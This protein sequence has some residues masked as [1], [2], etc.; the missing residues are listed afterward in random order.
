MIY[1]KVK[2]QFGTF[3][4]DG[5]LAAVFLRDTMRTRLHDAE[6]IVFDFEGVRN[7]N[8]SFCN[9]LIASLVHQLN[10]DLHRLAFRNCRP[11]LEILIRSAIE[12]G[13][14][15]SSAVSHRVVVR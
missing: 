9:S 2:E 8:S 1:V 11:G 12:M 13:L 10:G 6:E 14:A 5:E 7:M 15:R 4:A 3:C